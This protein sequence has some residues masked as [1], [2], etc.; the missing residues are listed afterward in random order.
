MRGLS[1]L[2]VS[3]F[4]W[5]SAAQAQSF[6]SATCSPPVPCPD[7]APVYAIDIAPVAAQCISTSFGY[8]A[9]TEWFDTYQ[10]LSGGNCLVAVP[11]MIPKGFGR[12]LNPVCCV[13]H[14][15]DRETCHIRCDLVAN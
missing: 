10:S 1:F 14:V 8:S 5:M 4:L 6:G 15:P 12:Q 13:V 3:S 2:F 11:N 7:Q 9:T